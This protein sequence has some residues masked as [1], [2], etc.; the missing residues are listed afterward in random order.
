MSLYREHKK[1]QSAWQDLAVF[2]GVLS[3]LGYSVFAFF[4]IRHAPPAK[5]I[6]PPE[7]E[8]PAS[9]SASR[10]LASQTTPGVGSTEV[11]RAPCL[12]TPSP[13]SFNSQ[14]RL[15]Q[16]HA[17]ICPTGKSHAL[18]WRASN[19]SSGE[20]ILVFV[21]EKEKSLSTSYFSLK[22]GVNQIVFIEEF[23]PGQSRVDK[24]Q[25]TRKVD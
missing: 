20:E 18:S 3:F 11:L 10:Q 6:P 12:Q 21:N 19:E 13:L 23:S 25:I 9:P 2:A 24:V 22:E 1:P 15:L 17:P 16:I 8:A 14:A 4:G 7:V 5:D